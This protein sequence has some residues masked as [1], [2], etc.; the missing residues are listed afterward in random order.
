MMPSILSSAPVPPA[1]KHPHKHDAIIPVLH[2][3]NGVLRLTSVPLFPPNIT[4]VI[5]AKQLYFSLHQTRGHFSKKVW[6]LSP[7]AIVW[8][9]N[10][11]FGALSSSLLKWPFRLCW[12]RTRFTEYIDT[13]VPWSLG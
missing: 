7:C 8:L 6:S 13:F 9:F 5:M 12:Y 2:G 1:A 11:G 4:T 3:R 10:G